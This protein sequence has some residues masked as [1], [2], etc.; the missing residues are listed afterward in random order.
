M[1]DAPIKNRVTDRGGAWGTGVGFTKAASGSDSNAG[2][3]GPAVKTMQPPRENDGTSRNAG[4]AGRATVDT[5][6]NGGTQSI[7]TGSTNPPR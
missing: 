1:N 7:R 4:R 5:H 6:F 2:A 3:G